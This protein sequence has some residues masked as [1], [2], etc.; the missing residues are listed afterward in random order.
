MK[1][2]TREWKWRWWLNIV[3]VVVVAVLGVRYVDA[4]NQTT[5]K[6]MDEYDEGDV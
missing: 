2:R 3:V 4:Q 1:E 5:S 6:Y